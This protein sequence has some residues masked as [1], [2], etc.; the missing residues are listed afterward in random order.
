MVWAKGNKDK[1]GHNKYTP[2]LIEQAREYLETFKTEHGHEIPSVVGLARVTGIRRETF[3]LWI[4][5]S[6]E[7]ERKDDERLHEIVDVLAAINEMQE[8]TL[9]NGGLSGSF[10]ANIAKLALGKHGYHDKQ[11]STLSAPGGGAVKTQFIFTPVGPDH[12]DD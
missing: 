5:N 4:R 12:E 7:E 9:M 2:E 8:L 1:V 11:D 6:K 3:Y 10:N